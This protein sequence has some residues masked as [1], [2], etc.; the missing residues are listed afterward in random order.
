MFDFILDQNKPISRLNTMLSN[1]TV[2]HALMFSG[3]DGV[4]KTTTA[5][6]FSMVLNC[7]NGKNHTALSTE[8]N[9]CS[10]RSCRK[11]LSG[12]HPDIITIRSTGNLI[13]IGQIRELC[14]RLLVKPYEASTRVVIIHDA[15]TMNPESGNALL[16]VLEE[17]PEKTLFILI[18]D[19][20]SDVLPTILSR[21]QV[22]SFNPVSKET[23]VSHLVQKGVAPQ[24]AAMA[25]SMSGGS[26]GKAL[27][28]CEK[29]AKKSD[30]HL[31]R[32]VLFDDFSAL[33]KGGALD[34]LT[35]SEHFSKKKENVLN[36]LE[37]LL[38]YVRDLIVYPFYKEMVVNIDVMDKI[39]VISA[40]KSTSSLIEIADCI[41]TA[42]QGIKANASV[43]LCLETMAIKIKRI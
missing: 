12:S 23:I 22:V 40:L 19:Q 9:P 26:I 42:H 11:I 28:L 24:W 32:R 8:Y 10:C 18:T 2:P 27:A 25:A 39:S 3:L 4:G 15:H 35:F 16:K 21:C 13:K 38:S 43:R 7:H 34:I 36:T 20:A 6:A 37:I 5:V 31:F 30:P 29:G 33:L 14:Q 17:P 1:R 41:T